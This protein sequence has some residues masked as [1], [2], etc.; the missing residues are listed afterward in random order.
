M[1]QSRAH[2]RTQYKHAS[3]TPQTRLKHASIHNLCQDASATKDWNWSNVVETGS[4]RG[5]KDLPNGP[6]AHDG[7]NN[8]HYICCL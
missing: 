5:L 4:R 7:G 2:F 6:I 1:L 8:P 3:N